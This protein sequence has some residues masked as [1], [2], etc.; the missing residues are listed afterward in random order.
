MAP[1]PIARLVA[2]LKRLP[3]VGE[4][5]AMRLAFFLLRQ[6]PEYARE[7]AEALLDVRERIRECEVC[8]NFTAESPCAFCRDARRDRSQI[9]VV[10]SVPDLHA[11]EK[12]GF[13][14]LYHVLHGVLAPLE[15]VGPE[16]LRV[17]ELL[18]RLASGEAQ[19]VIVATSPTVE[20]ETTALYLHKL[21]SPL[22][23]RVTR[24]AAGVPM[25]GDLEFADQV[26]LARALEGR[27]DMGRGT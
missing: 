16:Q 26:T 24:I 10:A 11:V 12:S 17:Q 18:R 7:L 9:C 2:A 3:G 23:T 19:E 15:G 20:G 25:G 5:T 1:D 14:G 6:P 27:R 8:C 22:G 4:K 13:R 21:L